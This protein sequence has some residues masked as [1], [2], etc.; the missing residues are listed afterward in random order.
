[1]KS[2][3]ILTVFLLVAAL[4]WAQL[5]ED[6]S[7]IRNKPPRNAA[8]D[9]F[10]NIRVA[11]RG[12]FGQNT[13]NFNSEFNG[14]ST[15]VK[16]D[17]LEFH[18]WQARITSLN[19]Q[20]EERRKPTTGKIAQAYS[21]YDSQVLFTH[22]LASLLLLPSSSSLVSPACTSSSRTTRTTSD[23]VMRL[24]VTS[25]S[26]RRG[27]ESGLLLRTSVVII[28]RLIDV[29]TIPSDQIFRLII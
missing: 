6:R 1:M 9:I 26:R 25:S 19:D 18:H 27:L 10:S 13:D 21:Y 3:T 17:T 15:S 7:L 4:T 11:I 16:Q 23:H 14:W 8:D 22:P 5:A 29:F 12:R 28:V 2:L 24:T 20:V